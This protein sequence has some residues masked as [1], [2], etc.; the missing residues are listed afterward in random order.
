MFA[1]LVPVLQQPCR[2]WR[3]C[4]VSLGQLAQ[5]KA[6]DKAGDESIGLMVDGTGET[7]EMA[8]HPIASPY[9]QK[10]YDA[11]FK[12]NQETRYE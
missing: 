5:S 2:C 6:K 3:P 1:N 8:R 7:F 4:E 10:L 9:L 11:V 12:Q